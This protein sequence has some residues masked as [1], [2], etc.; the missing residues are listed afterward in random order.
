VQNLS[1]QRNDT[2]NIVQEL[3]DKLWTVASTRAVFLDFTVYN[4]NLNL[5]CVVTMTFEFPPSGGVVP[6]SNFN[7]VKLLTLVSK[8]DYV[9]MIIQII[10][11]F[12]TVY[13]LIEEITEVL[14]VGFSIYVSNTWN[15]IDIIV[16]LLSIF[17]QFISL[18]NFLIIKANLE[19]ILAQPEAFADFQALAFWSNMFKWTLG[20][21][22]FFAWIKLF[23]YVSFNKTMSQLSLTITRSSGDIG[24][25]AVMFFIVFF[26][27]A[28]LGYLTFGTQLADY[29]SLPTTVITLVRFILGDYSLPDL[30]QANRLLGPLFFLTYVFFVF[31]V[32]LNMF[33]AI[34]NDTY[35]VV[36]AELAQQ[37]DEFNLSD[38]LKRSYNNLRSKIVT[39]NK[40]LDVQHIF[41]TAQEDADLG[42]SGI[43]QK[44]KEYVLFLLSQLNFFIKISQNIS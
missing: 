24:G 34:I 25:F 14:H 37:K 10:Y 2:E 1:P 8:A 7:T 12:F 39:R 29:Q 36:K 30:E 38:F 18:Y 13:Y 17:N 9:V 11:L 44:L 6:S 21:C 41:Q 23:K 5:F 27:F 20:L 42:Y 3:K 16:L 35:Q 43:R 19:A 4:A 32:L 22:I 40:L 31:F 15:Q 33:L 28:E 26:A